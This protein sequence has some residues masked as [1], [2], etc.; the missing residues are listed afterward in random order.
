MLSFSISRSDG[1]DI[2]VDVT[3]RLQITCDGAGMGLL[4][5]VLG[6]LIKDR[7]GHIHLR[8]PS[9]AARDPLGSTA[10]SEVMIDYMEGDPLEEPRS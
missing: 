3:H 1:Q 7:G 6:R 8:P 4:V 9:I 10:Y 2:P 5:E